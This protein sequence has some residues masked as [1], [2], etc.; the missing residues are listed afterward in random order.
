MMHKTL[1]SEIL[2]LELRCAPLFHVGSKYLGYK[3]GKFL[4]DVDFVQVNRV[5]EIL[6][7][8]VSGVYVK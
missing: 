6:R 5:F 2:S 7:F 8:E 3:C 4:G 1:H